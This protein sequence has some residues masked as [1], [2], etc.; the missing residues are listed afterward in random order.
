M[1]ILRRVARNVS[2][3]ATASIFYQKIGFKALRQ[4]V[5][6]LELAMVLGV[7]RVLSLRLILG[8]Q[9]LE[10]TQ[11][12]PPG[13][14]FPAAPSNDI[15]FQHIAIMTKNIYKM[16]DIALQAGA[17][18]ISHQGPQQLPND[19][20]GA[21][22]WKFRDLDQHPLEFLQMPGHDE[23]NDGSLV[24]GYDHSAICVSDISHSIGYYQSLGLSLRH[25]HLNY[26]IA[27]ARLD[28]LAVSTVEV[29]AMVP[30]Q[31]P[32]HVELLGY[33]PPITTHHVIQPNDI[34]A[35]RLVFDTPTDEL[36][37]QRDPDGHL[38]LFDG[39]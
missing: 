26:G 16:Y 29:A 14:A 28:G 27:Q 22:A 5:E 2:D 34:A 38:L 24:L 10:L 12:T 19:S 6:D 7:G 4:T 3:L 1:M 37:L 21:I 17:T 33:Q 18:P 32:P 25:R 13:A 23:F 8:A 15:C 31:A 36:V 9:H 20:G 30:V 39:R 11:C 35:D